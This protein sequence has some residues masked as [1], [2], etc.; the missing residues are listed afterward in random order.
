VYWDS[1]AFIG[2]LNREPDKINACSDVWVEA[3]NGYTTIYT[4]YLAFTEVYKVKCSV[5]GTALTIEEDKRIEQVLQ[6]RW[7]RPV[8]VDERIAI[9]ARRLLRRF[10]PEFKKPVDGIHL[11]TAAILNVDEM[12]TFDGSDLLK[13]DGKVQKEDGTML[14]I[15]LPSTSGPPPVPPMSEQD[16]IEFEK[17]LTSKGRR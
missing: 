5:P 13:L 8:I 1:C 4:S 3:Q 10:S 15:C 9:G 6:Q 7:I 12:H 17:E 14:K 11:A 2:L 16:L